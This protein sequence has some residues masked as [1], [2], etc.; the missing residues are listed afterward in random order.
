MTCRPRSAAG[1]RWLRMRR[2]LIVWPLPAAVIALAWLRLEDQRGAGR[3]VVA[4]LVLALLPALLGSA[5]ARRVAAGAAL[6][7]A[8]VVAADVS[9][10]A[11]A[12][13][14]PFF[15]ALYD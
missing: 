13:R 1:A 2:T 8:A 12:H 4:L 5:L 7:V 14:E 11:L 3:R 9:P 15:S 10:L 6:L